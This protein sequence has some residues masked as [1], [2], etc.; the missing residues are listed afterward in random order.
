ME[1]ISINV[2]MPVLRELGDKTYATAIGKR[3]VEGAVMMGVD[4]FDG[5]GVGNHKH[6]GGADQAVYACASE[7][8]DYWREELGREG[9]AYGDFGENLTA[10]GWVDEGVCIGDTYRVGDAVV[11]V[12]WP[13]I[14]CA[15]LEHHVG[16]R[17]FA[18]RYAKSRRFG[19][20]LRVV[21]AGVVEAGD[22]V[23]LIEKSPDGLGVIE[24]AELFMYRG[25][26]VEGMRRALGVEGLS[27]RGRAAFEKRVAG[28]DG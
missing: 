7:H 1:I 4:G 25:K 10:A 17:G 24:A 21:E 11:R 14:P 15:T 8:Y 27:E 22:G 2:A 3:A 12:T 26:D 23:T 20:Y 9:L 19:F 13:R 28:A 16:E 5:D 6:H 18:K